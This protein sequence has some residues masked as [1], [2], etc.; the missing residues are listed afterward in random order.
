MAHSLGCDQLSDQCNRLNRKIRL[1]NDLDPPTI[2]CGPEKNCTKFNAPSFCNRLQTESHGFHQNAQENNC[3]T[4][5]AKSVSGCYIV[6]DKQPKLDTC[7]ERRH[8][9]CEHDTSDSVEDRLL[10][11]TSQTEKAGLLKN[12]C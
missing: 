1:L 4:D 2:Q 3:L 11:K 12:D 8:P 6:F 7:Y 9:V 5:N 10:I